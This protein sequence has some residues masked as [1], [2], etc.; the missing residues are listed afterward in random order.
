VKK[1]FDDSFKAAQEKYSTHKA[2]LENNWQG[3]KS[4]DR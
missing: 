1:I 3:F 2:A 4:W